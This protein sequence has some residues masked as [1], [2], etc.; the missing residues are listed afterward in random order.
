MKKRRNVANKGFTLIE[1]LVV[2][3]I[4]GVLAA[5]ALPQYQIVVGKTKFSELKT[6]TKTF[7]QAAQRYYMINNTY[8]GINGNINKVLDIELPAESNCQI[9]DESSADMIRCCKK[10]F[11]T[12]MCFY[13]YRESGLPYLCLTFSTDKSDIPNRLC[14]NETGKNTECASSY[15]A[16]RY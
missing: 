6:L 3:L 14:H 12:N 2:V 11:N 5:I 9:W 16:Y 1:F 7:Q 10:I 15:C 4:I 13:S 8:E